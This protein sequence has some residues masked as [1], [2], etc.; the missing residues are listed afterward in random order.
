MNNIND[1]NRKI[2][3]RKRLFNPSFEGMLEEGAGVIILEVKY[4][5]HNDIAF[6]Y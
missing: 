1:K 2:K 3:A 6:R 5:H 4:P